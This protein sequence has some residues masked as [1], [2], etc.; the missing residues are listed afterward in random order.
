MAFAAFIINLYTT[1]LFAGINL[2][3]GISAPVSSSSPYDNII[4]IF[5]YGV[6]IGFGG[7]GGG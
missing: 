2:K 4:C 6:I 3:I 7:S 1:S 5:Y